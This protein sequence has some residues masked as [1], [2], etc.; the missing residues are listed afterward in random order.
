MLVFGAL[1][2]TDRCSF[3]IHEYGYRGF[4]VH[5]TEYIINNIRHLY[6]L[7]QV[8]VFTIG[9]DLFLFNEEQTIQ[10]C[11]AMNRNFPDAYFALVTRANFLTPRTMEAL[12]NANCYSL[13]FGFESGSDRILKILMKRVDRMTNISAYQ[14]IL[15]TPI[16][17]AVSFMVGT[18][19]E[20]EDTIRDTVS[21][22]K[23]AGVESGGI[24]YTT[25]YP[26]SR[27]F[28]WCMEKGFITNK[29][30]Y[31]LKISNRDASKL[32]INLTPYPDLIVKMMYVIIQ[33]AILSTAP[34]RAKPGLESLHEQFFK[35]ALVPLAFRSYFI[36][37]KLLSSI[38][39]RYSIEAVDQSLL[40]R[41]HLGLSTD[42]AEFRP[43]EVANRESRA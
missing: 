18:P 31:L 2:C 8:R 23:E 19:G 17:P 42:E 41:P 43:G 7:Y 13:N 33:N 3:C 14:K 16:T 30:E 32:S 28:R 10:F 37:R 38:F 12:K 34:E 15:S 26:G 39:P 27:L 22:I 24:F 29:E 21:A 40:H 9:E 6:D 25:P 36:L 4:R 35:R 20:T 1:G 11:E 5:S